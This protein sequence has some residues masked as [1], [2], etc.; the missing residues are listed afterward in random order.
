MR[1]LIQPLRSSQLQHFVDLD[2]SLTKPVSGAP[3]GMN[4]KPAAVFASSVEHAGWSVT[5]CY[6][7]SAHIRLV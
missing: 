1:I 7:T 2:Y 5:V 4:K 3:A 6:A